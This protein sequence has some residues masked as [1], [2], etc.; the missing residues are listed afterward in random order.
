MMHVKF[1]LSST[2]HEYC[3]IFALYAGRVY[4]YIPCS[5]AQ[6]SKFTVLYSMHSISCDVI[7]MIGLDMACT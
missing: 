7:I 2:H 3:F 5:Q 4:S 1:D 6:S